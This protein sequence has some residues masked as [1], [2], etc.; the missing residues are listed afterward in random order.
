[1]YVHSEVWNLLHSLVQ[2]TPV[3]LHHTDCLLGGP[4]QLSFGPKSSYN[5]LCRGM[6]EQ[7]RAPDSSSGVS[8]QQSVGSSLGH[9]TCVFEQDTLPQLLCPSDGTLEPIT[10]IMEE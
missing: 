9:C 1:M 2:D 8:K 3:H 5:Q 4:K 7:L 10:L 6:V